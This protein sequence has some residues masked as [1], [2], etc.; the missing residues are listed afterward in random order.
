MTMMQTRRRF[1]TMTALAGA[2]GILPQRRARGPNRTGSEGIGNFGG[3]AFSRVSRREGGL[4]LTA[5]PPNSRLGV[6]RLPFENFL[7][8]RHHEASR[9]PF[10]ANFQS[11][12]PVGTQSTS[13]TVPKLPRLRR[14]GAPR[15]PHG[16][17]LTLRWRERDS[18]FRSPCE[19]LRFSR[20]SCRS[21]RV[22]SNSIT[23]GFNDSRV[24]AIRSKCRTH[25]TMNSSTGNAS[26]KWLTSKF[27]LWGG[28]APAA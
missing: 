10:R 22:S 18:N 24:D 23:P 19:K 7:M 26:P 16:S 25:A 13:L 20:G 2:A 21:S 6:G 11:I 14:Q 1:L 8:N 5:P 17:L 3:V 9:S 15:Q 28:T 27:R 4:F 12:R